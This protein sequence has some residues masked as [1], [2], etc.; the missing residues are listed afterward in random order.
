MKKCFDLVVFS[1]LPLVS[2]SI[3]VGQGTFQNLDFE[4]IDLN[5]VFSSSSQTTVPFAQ[6]LPGWTGYYGTNQTTQALMNGISF[7][8][9]LITVV[10]INSRPLG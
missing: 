2:V 9:V 4:S 10:T 8:G 3:A 1:C 5:L 7:G 6:A